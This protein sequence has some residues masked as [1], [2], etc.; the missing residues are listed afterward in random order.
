MVLKRTWSLINYVIGEYGRDNCNQ[1]A[2]AISYY[3]L[4]S[5]VPF[6]V[7]TVSIFGVVVGGEKLQRQ[8]TPSIVDFIGLQQGTPTI[9]LDQ[10]KVSARLGQ[11]VAAELG[12]AATSLT[13]A[14]ASAIAAQLKQTSSQLVTIGG[15]QV[16]P[17]EVHVTYDNPVANTLQNVSQ[18]SAPLTAIGFV[19]LAW[20]S[21]A[22]FGAVRRA[23]QAVWKVERQRP[24]FQQ[25]LRD[26]I[27][28]AFLGA[29]LLISIG[30]TGLLQALRAASDRALGPLSSNTGIFWA[31]V[32][33]VLPFVFTFL[34]ISLTYRF[35]PGVHVRFA[36]V[37]PGALFAGVLFEVLKNAFAFYVAHFPAYDIL[38]GSLGGILLFLTSVYL[39]AA[40]LLFGGELTLAWPRLAAGEFDPIV[41]P[42]AP[43]PG[44]LKRASGDVFSFVRGLFLAQP[45]RKQARSKGPVQRH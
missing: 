14:E 32:P 17:D 8:V 30:A 35:A 28:T 2:A 41:D 27:M 18:V 13:P 45:E 22:M 11:T 5:I 21:S 42:N 15:R 24:F 25:K 29:L 34:V 40:I 37:W 6:T 23:L 20:S 10:A 16:S 9:E 38:Y 1:L 44:F 26:L 12:T 31:V 3:V 36:S 19:F 7:F 43:R 33:Y 39:S 4:F